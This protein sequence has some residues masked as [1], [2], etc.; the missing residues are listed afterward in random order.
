MFLHR[1]ATAFGYI[2]VKRLLAVL[3]EGLRGILDGLHRCFGAF[4]TDDIKCLVLKLVGC[5][6]KLFKLLTC[7]LREI[8]HVLKGLLGVRISRHRKEAV[9]A[10]GLALAL[11]LD[12]KNADYTASEDNARKGR[13]IVHDH[14]I[15]R[16]AVVSLGRRYEP[17]IVRISE[18]RKQ[19]L[20]QRKCLELWVIIELCATAA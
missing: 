19:R 7:R 14:D 10:F 13:G 18:A 3:L 5:L 15:D 6:E 8:A 4:P 16:I 2:D 20:R 12:L 9:I 17:P 11:L 1:L